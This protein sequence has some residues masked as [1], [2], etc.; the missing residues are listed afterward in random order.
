LG[1]PL[2][3]GTNF[4]P[5]QPG[6]RFGPPPMN[7]EEFKLRKNIELLGGID[8]TIPSISLRTNH[9]LTQ[10]IRYGKIPQR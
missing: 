1:N 6:N 5:N 9:L 7:E 10:T 3:S 2:G 4:Y 8:K